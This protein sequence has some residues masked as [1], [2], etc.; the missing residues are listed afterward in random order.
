MAQEVAMNGKK[1]EAARIDREKAD[2]IVQEASE[3][4]FPASD[5][6]GWIGDVPTKPQPARPTPKVPARGTR[7]GS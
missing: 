4:S 1:T 7:R 2:E 6:P 5:A 3:E